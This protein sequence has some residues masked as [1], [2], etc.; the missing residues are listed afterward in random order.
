MNHLSAGCQEARNQDFQVFDTTGFQLRVAKHHRLRSINEAEQNRS[1]K[2][3]VE[4]AIDLPAFLRFP[5]DSGQ[6][7]TQRS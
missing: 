3:G 6:Q 7:R 1:G 5:E 4:A 2:I